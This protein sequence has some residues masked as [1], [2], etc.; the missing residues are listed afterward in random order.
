[1]LENLEVKFMEICKQKGYTPLRSKSIISKDPTLLFINS[2]I[3]AFKDNILKQEQINRHAIVQDCFRT[4][5]L[6]SSL[7]FFR[8]FG[9]IGM[10]D[11]LY[12]SASLI[13]RY[14]SEYGKISLDNVFCVVHKNDRYLQKLCIDLGF[15]ERLLLTDEYDNNYSTRWK[16]GD[17]YNFFGK[18]LTLVYSNPSI[19]PCSDNCSILCGC[20]KYL[21]LGNIIIISFGKYEYIDIGFGLERLMSCRYTNDIFLIPEYEKKKNLIKIIGYEEVNARIVCNLLFSIQKLISE[22]VAPGNKSAGYIYKKLIRSLADKIF[23]KTGSYSFV[24]KELNTLCGLLSINIDDNLFSS[25]KNEI[26][27]YS[28]N[29]ERNQTAALKIL[30]KSVD[31]E[32]DEVRFILRDRFGLP[33]SIICMM[34]DLYES[35]RN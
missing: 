7:T 9:I 17:T 26:E 19:V 25:V 5:N 10:I 30:K 22:D 13:C 20:S 18:G 6:S 28:Y 2:T 15:Q 11:C 14:I 4:N 23:E 34:V 31:L 32:E 1:M 3:V 33:E 29:I 35:N 27:C 21:Q 24:N 16:Y 12:D 8:M